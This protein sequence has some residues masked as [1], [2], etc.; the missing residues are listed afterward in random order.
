MLI[1]SKNLR[2]FVSKFIKQPFYAMD[3]AGKRLKAYQAYYLSKGKSA[4]PESITFFLTHRCNLRC[5]MCGQWGESGVTKTKSP[6]IIK[7]E[8]SFSQL[9]RV[10][11]DVAKF[12]PSITLFG[13]EPLL[14]PQIIELIQEIKQ[15]KMHCLMIT[16]GSLLS[17]TAEKIASTGLDE[18]NISLDGGAKLHNEIRGLPGIFE[19]IAQGIK[20]INK[21]KKL[22]RTKKPLINL[23]C[24][25]TKYNYEHLDQLIDAANELEADSLT[26]HNLIFLTPEL[27]QK[28]KVFDAE[29]NCSSCN[30]E[31]FIFEPELD[32]D[33]LYKNVD[34]ILSGKHNFS[35]DFYPNL[36]KTGL[37]EYYNNP[38]YLPKEYPRRCLS[39]WIV[40][41]LFPDGEV[42]PCLNLSYSFGNIK[43]KPFQE[44]WN[45]KEALN[46]RRIL[47]KQSIFPACIRC[48]ELYRY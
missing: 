13:G 30:W 24:T 27:M 26:Y 40:A 12:K 45:S 4:V 41:Y 2:R 43:E 19:K 22:N 21:Y 6:E 7:E 5:K 18:L 23:Q 48:T 34:K 29:L 1:P 39:P 16:N 3:V 20:E 38:N 14:Y 31:G 32:P 42:R 11:I 47:K 35:V 25:I 9:Q 8:L 33:K 28:Q 10:V 17:N 44:V 36:T 15:N 46:Y 37:K